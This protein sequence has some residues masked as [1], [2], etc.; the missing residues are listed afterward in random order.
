MRQHEAVIKVMTDNGGYA[1]L[2]NLYSRVLKVPDVEWK[3]KTPFASIRRIVQDSR[4][5]YKIRPGLWALKGWEKRIPFDVLSQANAKLTSQEEFD[6]TY[7]QGLLVELGNVKHLATFVPYQDKNRM[8][9]DRPLF[10]LVTVKEFYP[11][12]YTNLVRRAQTVD[13]TWF[14]D[15]KM[16]DTFFE[17]EHS[18]DIYNSLLKYVD[19]QD[20]NAKFRIVADQARKK[21]FESRLF[22]SAFTAIAK[23]VGFIS[24]DDLSELHSKAFELAAV[25][26]RL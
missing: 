6:H 1:T 7:Y 23:R 5:F 21:E 3:T 10:R 24:Y 16:P 26:G 11:F 19:L 13:V 2:G 8:F 4:F 17:V 22:S 15:R 9:L 18:T 12:T 25:E 20:F 14:N